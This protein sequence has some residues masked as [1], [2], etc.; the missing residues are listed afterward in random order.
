MPD[1]QPAFP[2]LPAANTFTRITKTPPNPTPRIFVHR[3]LVFRPPFHPQAIL[4]H[5]FFE[6]DFQCIGETRSVVG[7]FH[8]DPTYAGQGIGSLPGTPAAFTQRSNPRRCPVGPIVCRNWQINTD[9]GYMIPTSD[10]GIAHEHAKYTMPLANFCLFGTGHS[11]SDKRVSFATVADFVETNDVGL[12]IKTQ[13][14][15][16]IETNTKRQRLAAPAGRRPAS[17]RRPDVGK[18]SIALGELVS[19]RLPNRHKRTIQPAAIESLAPAWASSRR[20]AAEKGERMA[21]QKFNGRIKK[22][23]FVHR[24]PRRLRQNS[25]PLMEQVKRSTGV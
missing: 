2:H 3:H 5:S 10:F 20:I 18:A 17:S 1:S 13:R 19:K 14:G 12:V 9:Y 23:C 21:N 6:A 15:Q 11:H 22:I 16:P 4:G 24:Y 8:A 7:H 25:K